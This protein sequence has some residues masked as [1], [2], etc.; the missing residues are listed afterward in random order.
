MKKYLVHIV[1]A[2][3]CIAWIM[4]LF[5][6]LFFEGEKIEQVWGQQMW[7]NANVIPN[8]WVIALLPPANTT[9]DEIFFCKH[10]CTTANASWFDCIDFCGAGQ[11]IGDACVGS[12]NAA[13][14]CVW[15]CASTFQ[16]S[17]A[18]TSC[19]QQ[20]TDPLNCPVGDACVW[21][22]PQVTISGSVC[23]EGCGSLHMTTWSSS[24]LLTPTTPGLCSWSVLI[25]WSLM[26]YPTRWMWECSWPDPLQPL[27]GASACYM[28]TTWFVPPPSTI[29]F[30]LTW[31]LWANGAFA[32]VNVCGVTV[33]ANASGVFSRSAILSGSNCASISAT[34]WGYTCTITTQWPN[35]LLSDINNVL[36]SCVAKPWGGKPSSIWS[37]WSTFPPKN[38]SW[39]SNWPSTTPFNKHFAQRLRTSL[40][41]FETS[42][43]YTD[44]DYRTIMFQDIQRNP[45]QEDIK[46]LQAYCIVK[47]YTISHNTRYHSEAATSIWEAIKVLTKIAAMHEGVSFDEFGW[48]SGRLPYSDMLPNARYTP[49]VV[50]ADEHGYLEWITSWKMFGRGELKA[51][52]PISKKQFAQLLE[53]FWKDASMY[54]MFSRSWKYVMRDEMAAVVVDAFADDLVDYRYLYGNNT[55]FYRWLLARLEKKNNQKAYLQTLVTNLKKRDADIMGRKY[56]LDVEGIILFLEELLEE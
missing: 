35:P 18:R 12:N 16:N 4:L 9:C 24:T 41:R 1:S 7:G 47:W 51:L 37:G 29:S 11:N 14:V 31:T 25:T 28:H 43:A 19:T 56:N 26:Q 22:A 23:Q 36:G 42:C 34:K 55:I 21:L 44:I 53:N 40:D 30:T 13:G 39:G 15:I 8:N 52:T 20:P 32:Q 2:G 38:T 27:S 6:G 3:L 33:N 54:E 45:D 5:F 10:P 48:Y 17:N 49:Y 50:Y 46:T